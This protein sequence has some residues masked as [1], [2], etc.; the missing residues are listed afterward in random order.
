MAQFKERVRDVN[1]RVRD[2]VN[3]QSDALGKFIRRTK[4]EERPKPS[5]E[6][7]LEI[8]HAFGTFGR[9][10][11]HDHPMFIS[12][13]PSFFRGERFSECE[14]DTVRAALRELDKD[15]GMVKMERLYDG[16]S[17]TKRGVEFVNAM[18]Q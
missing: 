5:S 6:L 9:A 18:R 11:S 4:Q 12:E 16:A 3:N 7:H 14:I 8:M 15:M 17:L 13:I 10:Y 1:I 2:Y